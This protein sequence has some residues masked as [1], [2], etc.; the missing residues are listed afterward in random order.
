MNLLPPSLK[1]QSQSTNIIYT[2]RPIVI[3]FMRLKSNTF[4]KYMKIRTGK[5]TV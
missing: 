1:H 5:K 4:L 3:L 2:A